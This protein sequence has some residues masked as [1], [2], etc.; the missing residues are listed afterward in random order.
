ML[1]VQNNIC[2]NAINI[3][4][5]WKFRTVDD[6]FT[7][8]A[9]LE[10]F[11][12]M[13]VP[14]SMNDVV[15]DIALRE[16]VGKVAYETTFSCPAERGREY[17]VRIGATSH[18]C[19]V[20]LNG[21]CLG[22]SD[23]GSAHV[24]SYAL[25]KAVKAT[26]TEN[27][28]SAYYACDCGKIFLKKGV[29]YVET[30]LSAVTIK[31]KGH[32]YTQE[33]TSDEYLV[34]E[35]TENAPQTFAKAC[36]LCGAKSPN[37]IDT[38]TYGKTLAE[39]EKVNKSL[40]APTNLTMTLYDAAN[41]VYGFT[42]NTETE[43]A[44]PVL[45]VKDE[46]GKEENVR[47]SFA[48]ASSQKIENGNDVAIKYYSCKAE[49]T[50]NPDSVYEYSVGD[51]YMNSFTEAVKI[52]T[53]NPSEKGS[54]KFV[55]VSDS[56]AEG[57]K[58]NGGLGTGTAFSSVLKNVISDAD[59]KFMV[60]T[61]DVV[62]YSKYQSYW[63]NMLDANFKYLSK[64]PV[65]A[66]SGNHETTYKNGSNETFNRFD[67]K[68]PVQANTK[69]GFYYSFSYGN[70]K[71][72]M[73]NTNEL[74]G[75]RL[76]N[77]QYSWLE[78][79]LQNKT[80]KWTVVTMHNPMYS[81]GKWGSDN[82]KNGIALAL[83][84]QLKGLFA[85]N[86]VDV[87]LQG[88][89]HMVSRTYPLNAKGEATKEK[90]EKIGGIEYIKDPSGVIYVMNGPAGDQAKGESSIYKHDESLYAYAMA[91]KISSWAE[92]EVEGDTL[93]VTVKTAQSGTATD[94]L[95]WGIIKTK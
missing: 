71:F 45:V 65:M 47:A 5:I 33:I 95:S 9:P 3:D 36:K 10:N 2:R 59:V 37:E 11:R 27:G 32:T 50:L 83:A 17:R 43:P 66:I 31:A 69:L 22:G 41:C 76:T 19:K 51:K 63:D 81:V 18:K 42:W 57:N 49:L 20:Y 94:E 62:E 34:S 44:R 86:G 73:L 88:H 64:I 79:E 67:Y 46:N 40:Y 56:Q 77:A 74:N 90:T 93:T 35:A 53:V 78:N 38:Y 4:G 82:T 84:V 92:F 91:S 29:D 80:E 16:Y 72:I 89:D 15:T 48:E 21:D 24:H 23:T 28:N 58:N 7:P 30:D 87:V 39:Y 1:K 26:C 6:G 70:V 61:G 12:L 13:P 68:I 55:H 85:D 8:A 25:V 14:A 60:H 54:W 52:K 75:S